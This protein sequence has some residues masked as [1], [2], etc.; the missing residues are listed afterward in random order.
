MQRRCLILVFLLLMPIHCLSSKDKIKVSKSPLTPE[1]LE[2]YG[3]F[4]DSYLPGSAQPIYL[5][6]KT[7]ALTL[8]Y[9]DIHGTCLSGIHIDR[10]QETINIVH[11]L[12]TD[13]AN[14][15]PLTLVKLKKNNDAL[16][17]KISAQ[18]SRTGAT[19]EER[20][21]GILSVSE[22]AFDPSHHFAVFDFMLDCGNVCGHS[23]TVVYEKIDGKWRDAKRACSGFIS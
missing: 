8:T 19:E 5:S 3:A 2:V 6:N 17:D 22:I 15:R 13:M 7:H 1:Q 23:R 16:L 4:L 10:S 20:E 14:G 11:M 9:D 18:A 12:P 21:P